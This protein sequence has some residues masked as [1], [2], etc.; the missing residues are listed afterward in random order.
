MRRAQQVVFERIARDEGIF[1][2]SEGEVIKVIPS[3]IGIDGSEVKK[4]GKE[5]SSIV[6]SAGSVDFV[7]KVRILVDEDNSR[8]IR[9]S[10]KSIM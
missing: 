8:Y 7:I 2:E 3:I 5:S 9:V 6:Y 10:K 1:I 4:I